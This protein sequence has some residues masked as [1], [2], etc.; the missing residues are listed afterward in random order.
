[1][2]KKN[3]LALSC[4]SDSNLFI[5]MCFI[6]FLDSCYGNCV[7]DTTCEGGNCVCITGY[8]GDGSISCTIGNVL[9]IW[10]LDYSVSDYSVMYYTFW[11]LDYSV[12]Y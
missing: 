6:Y 8:Q 7:D 1:M 12:S 2:D 5:I 10:L 9:H 4:N 11:L 3:V